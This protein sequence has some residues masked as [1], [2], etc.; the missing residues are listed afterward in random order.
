MS[1][2]KQV[3]F[4]EK[5]SKSALGLKGLQ[6]VVYCDRCRQECEKRTLQEEQNIINKEYDFETIGKKL[7]KEI[8]GEFIKNKYNM[9]EGI[10]FQQKL[11]EE[12]V[13]WLKRQK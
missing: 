10:E 3:D 13:L 5:V 8:N 7:I 2:K 11:H 12:R 4:I 6:I 9:Q 1:I